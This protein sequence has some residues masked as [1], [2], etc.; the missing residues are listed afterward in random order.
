MTLMQFFATGSAD[1]SVIMINELNFAVSVFNNVDLNSSPLTVT[2]YFSQVKL[3][4]LSSKKPSLVASN[5]PE[6]VSVFFSLIQSCIRNY[7]T[8]HDNFVK[9]L[10]N[11]FFLMVFV[12]GLS[13]LLLS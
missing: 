13:S 1:E 12:R 4:D 9:L 3:W 8:N 11:D 6:A 5:N 2:A 7:Y 10:L